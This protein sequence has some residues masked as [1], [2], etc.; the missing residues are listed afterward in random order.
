MGDLHRQI[1][2]SLLHPATH[3]TKQAFGIVHIAANGAHDTQEV[4]EGIRP[5]VSQG[6]ESQNQAIL[7]RMRCLFA[8][9]VF[10]VCK[11]KVAFQEHW[12]RRLD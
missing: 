8:T 10:S 7:A 11:E 6:D 5:A 3:S 2:L 9:S 1:H 12:K 4:A